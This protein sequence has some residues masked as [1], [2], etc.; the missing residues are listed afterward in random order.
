MALDPVLLSRKRGFDPDPWQT[1]VLRSTAPRLPLNCSRQ[2]GKSTT[3]TTLTLHTA[4]CQPKS[5]ILL[6]SPGLRQTIEFFKKIIAACRALGRPVPAASE[7]ALMLTLENSSRIVALP[8]SEASVRGYSGVTV[9][10]TPL[11]QARL[12]SSGMD[13]GA[14]MATVCG[15]GHGLPTDQR[16]LPGGRA[17]LARSLVVS[18]EVRQRCSPRNKPT[19][20]CLA[21]G[22]SRCSTNS[23]V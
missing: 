3:T 19:Q 14:G 22:P 4:S 11:G 21:Y 7:T 16:A 18:P 13:G 1:Q 5:K 2:L 10:S 6:L 17:A 23:R 9:L 12:L 15:T 8:G 20:S